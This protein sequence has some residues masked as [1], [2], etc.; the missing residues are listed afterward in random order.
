MTPELED[1]KE[2]K[3]HCARAL[4]S[5]DA[6]RRL[7]AFA[8]SRFR[9]QLRRQIAA[10]SLLHADAGRQQPT[11]EDAWHLFESYAA[12]TTTR[13]GKRYK[14]WIFARVSD[15]STSPFDTIQSGA[16]LI[17]RSVVR[18]HLR[19][20]YAHRRSVS[21]DQPV[22]DG[23]LTLGD[24]LASTTDPADAATGEHDSMAKTHAA[25]LFSEL[26]HRERVGLLAKCMGI[27]LANASVLSAAGCRKSVLSQT[28]RDLF[29][30]IKESL[31]REFQEDGPDAVMAF[32]TMVLSGLEACIYSWKSSEKNLPQCFH[33]VEGNQQ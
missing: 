12:L 17:M 4:C 25:R 2:W 14:D 24:L 27:S 31:L 1:W 29:T 22:G 18:A 26:S 23:S 33:S 9:V 13:Q 8:H 7:A 11:A 32:S 10:T 5:E 15:S 16:S 28:V 6:Q 30:R 3:R 21:F 19:T 20:E